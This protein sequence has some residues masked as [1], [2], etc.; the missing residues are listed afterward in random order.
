ME[1]NL[2]EGESNQILLLAPNLLGESLAL[3]LENAEPDLK[4]LL[5]E[6]ALTRSPSLVIWILESVEVPSAIEL[7]LRNLQ[8]YWGKVPLLLILPAKLT[9][10]TNQFFQFDCPGLL[11]DPDFETLRESIETI[12]SGG[13]V[14][15]LKDQSKDPLLNKPSPIG[16][17]Q[18]FLLSGVQQIDEE[19]KNIEFLLNRTS[20]NSFK[21]IILYGRRKE[22]KAAKALLYWLWGPL[23]ISIHTLQY[24]GDSFDKPNQKIG[25][26]DFPQ[27]KDFGTTISL[28]KRDSIAVWE[29]IR[30]HIET[31]VQEG[32]TNST[33]SLLAIEGLNPTKQK[34]LLNALIKQFD[35]II[36]TLRSLKN[37]HKTY[38]KDWL[39]LQPELRQ[40]ALQS[41]AGSYVRLPF[42]GELKLIGEQLL[43]MSDLL[44]DDDELPDAEKMLDPLILNKPIIVDGQL[45]P[46]DDP[47]AF[48]Q[49]EMFISNWLIRISEIISAEVISACGE[50]PE[51]RG[52]LLNPELISTRELERLRNQLNSQNRWQ[53]LIKRPIQLYE[54]KR[55]FYNLNNG[56]IEQVLV[57]EPRD[58]ELRDLDWWQQQVALLVEARDAIAPQI[59]TLVKKFGDLM[60]V[61]LTQVIGRAIGLVGRGIAQGMGRNLR[62]S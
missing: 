54:S 28:R 48:I 14:V 41:L 12:I 33:D 8:E 59:Q 35:Q 50:W 9:L 34:A 16:L 39:E 18:W 61:L 5:E 20:N 19:I 42:N 46:A 53:N 26:F 37:D 13:R 21:E 62:R 23:K 10:K 15:R 51:L 11:Q 40:K 38:K 29:A 52:Y 55:L 45:L 32:L 22:L 27:Q 43:A 17:G 4:V 44:D 25:S 31:T 30:D 7:E 24:K 36:I 58:K 3:Q 49:L 1:T 6:N 47:R 56:R 2:A 57:T 60:V